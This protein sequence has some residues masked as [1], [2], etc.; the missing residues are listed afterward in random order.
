M[1]FAVHDFSAGVRLP[2]W[3]K[4]MIGGLISGTIG[5]LL[6]LWIGDQRVLDVLSFG[7]GTLQEY[8][9]FTEDP[10]DP[11]TQTHSISGG[12]SVTYEGIFHLPTGALKFDGNGQATLVDSYIIADTFDFNGNGAN[13]V[14]E[15]SA[16]SSSL[17]C[18]VFKRCLALLD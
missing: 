7:Y 5:V 9:V 13:L 14:L 12:A 4:P 10:N 11:P 15:N 18:T 3:L 8:L 16:G 6:F 2:S 17:S 1:F